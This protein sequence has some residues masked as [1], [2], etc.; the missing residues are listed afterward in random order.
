M[1]FEKGLSLPRASGAPE[2]AGKKKPGSWTKKK[3]KKSLKRLSP[4]HDFPKS[5]L[6]LRS[7]IYSRISNVLG[8][9]F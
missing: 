7:E 9:L 1:S 3:K 4:A 5:S 2:N 8:S 6:S